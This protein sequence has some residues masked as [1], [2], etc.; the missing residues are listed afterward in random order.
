M[1][2]Q[3]LLHIVTVHA[4]DIANRWMKEVRTNLDTI[5][6]KDIPEH[7][8]REAALDVYGDIA[9]WIKDPHANPS[10]VEER[11]TKRGA[12]QHK[13][14]FR[15]SETIWAWILMKHHL[16]EFLKEEG[17]F[18]SAT[19]LYQALELLQDLGNFMDRM[20]HFMVLG[21]EREASVEV[22][23]RP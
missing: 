22:W 13:L 19:E 16:W 5:A 17:L 21:Y 20:V 12:N 2:S 11:Y 4:E 18:N 15:L 8:L 14:G 6:Y 10:W 1:I 9:R 3:K 7:K 23:K